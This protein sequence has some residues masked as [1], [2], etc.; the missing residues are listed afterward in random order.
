MNKNIKYLLIPDV[1]GREFW[2]DPV[3]DVLEN[4]DANIVLLGDYLDCYPHEWDEGID[5]QRVAIDRF[6]E[7][8]EIK[9]A[10]PL[11][12]TLLLGNHDC[13]YCIGS[14]ICSC[15]M[16]H[17]NKRE[18]EKLFRDNRELFQIAKEVTV[19]NK[20]YNL[21]HA[22]ILKG[23]VKRVWGEEMDE[24]GFNVVDRLN[25]AWFTDQYGILDALGQYDGYRGWGGFEYGSPIWADIRSWINVKPEETYNYNIVGHTML[26]TPLVL[27]AITCLDCQKA[28][29]LD[30]DGEIR[31]YETDKVLD[32]TIISK[33][34]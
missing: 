8:L 17:K 12:I 33:E 19:G 24:E 29:Y 5:Y 28:F 34:S 30:E 6:K 10:N 11:R 15:R 21:S 14:H 13:G 2:I 27:D 23:W 31:D 16:D 4:T 7:I 20:S 26:Y 18:I 3:K 32:G 25:N 22:G 1:H 9:H